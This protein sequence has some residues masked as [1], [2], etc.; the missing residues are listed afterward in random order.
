M[1]YKYTGLGLNVSAV[2]LPSIES[3]IKKRNL[4]MFSDHLSTPGTVTTK[5]W[6]LLAAVLLI[7]CQLAALRFVVLGQV[8]AAE[9]RKAELAYQR[10][11]AAQCIQNSKGSA[12][13][14][15][16]SQVLAQ[17]APVVGG[18]EQVVAASTAGS[19]RNTPQAQ[20]Q[21]LMPVAFTVWQ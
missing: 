2:A 6:L 19:I 8:Q 20:S 3:G 13:K 17:G 5:T 15:C 11:A 7:V 18:S 14:A 12:H 16:I 1:S 9:L 4:I 10:L 21:G